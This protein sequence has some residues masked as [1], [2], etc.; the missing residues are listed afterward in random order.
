MTLNLNNDIWPQRLG[1][2]KNGMIAT[3]HFEATQAGVEMLEQG[4]NAIDAAVAAAFALGVCEP[5]ASGL[6][7]QTMMLIHTVEPKRTFAIDG[8]S[9]APNRATMERVPRKAMRLR[10]HRATTVPSTPAVLG[11]VL[12]NYGRL[13]LKKVLEP[14][15]RLAKEGYMI[16]QL[17]HDLQVREKKHWKEGNA[18]EFYLKKNKKPYVPGEIF[19]QPVLAKT[20]E[21]LRQKGIEEFYLGDMARQI[22]DD[23]AENNGFI[24]ADDLALVPYPIE[25][26]PV[27]CRFGNRRVLTF[28]PPGAGRTLVEM[29][30][31]ISQLNEKDYDLNTLKG[32]FTLCEVIRR[33]QLDR[34]DRPFEPNFYPQ[35][36]DRRMLTTEYAK[37]AAKQ[38]RARTRSKKETGETTHLSVMDKE[39]NVVALTQ[40]IERVYG[41][42]A[43]NPELGFL[44]NNYM[45]TFEYED[46]THPYYLRPNG[47]P[48]ASVAPTIIFRGQRPH[49]AIGSPGSDRIAS[50]IMQVLLRL[51]SGQPHLEAITAPRF[52][53]SIDG[54]V[55]MEASRFRDDLPRYLEKRGLSVVK[56]EPYAFYMGCVQM[57]ARERKNFFGVADMRRDGSACGPATIKKIVPPE[58]TS[59]HE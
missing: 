19:K 57:V 16:T 29:L 48:W 28:P 32:V 35:V 54:K 7:G 53:C 56:K 43:V 50:S 45:S 49:I 52:H 30:N 18:A 31:I 22:A 40:S 37:L 42:F 8:S 9:R 13:P 2:S 21:L 12:E 47:V 44:Y 33:A 46:I 36:Q 23:M 34:S 4:G 1:A 17:Q 26:R 38:I 11:Y 59:P 20:F 5:N 10:G 51:L 58:E 6:G 39:G 55:A 15:V 41:S 3:Q 27:S 24:Q 14:A 25:R